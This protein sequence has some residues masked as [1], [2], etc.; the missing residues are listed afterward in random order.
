ML[1][2]FDVESIGRF[3]LEL[4]VRDKVIDFSLYCPPPYAG[5]YDEVKNDLR[6]CA[7]KTGYRFGE[8]RVDRLDRPRSLMDVFKSLPYKRT[9]VDVTI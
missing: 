1:L 7:G 8:I 4:F 3:E 5:I 2:A 6:S 9:G